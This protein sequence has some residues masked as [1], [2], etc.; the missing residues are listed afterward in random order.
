VSEEVATTEEKGE[1]KV[2]EHILPPST[3]EEK[4]DFWIPQATPD[5]RLFYFNTLTGVSTSE[6]PLESPSPNKSDPRDYIP[7]SEPG[8]KSTST[9]S[10]VSKSHDTLQ[11]SLLM[12]QSPRL[13]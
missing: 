1:S 9:E 5:S 7:G 8:K 4:A 12:S 2:V 3:E 11:N 10:H 6:L 13:Y